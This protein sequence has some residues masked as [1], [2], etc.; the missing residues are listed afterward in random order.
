VLIKNAEALETMAKVNTLCIDKTGTL[1]EGRPQ[2]VGIE[3]SGMSEPD[4]IGVLASVEQGSEHPLAQAVLAAAKVRNIAPEPASGFQSH[5][6]KGV[7]ANVAAARIAF[8]N[9]LLMQEAGVELSNVKERAAELRGKGETVVFAAREDKYAGLVRMADPIKASAREALNE[10]R[11]QGIEVIM[12]TGDNQRTAQTIAQ[13]L[14]IARFEAEVLPQDKLEIV[15][16]LQTEGR[17]VAMA[18]DGINDAPALAQANVGIAMGSG[19]DIAMESADVTLVKGDLRG[20]L[21]AH[22]LSVATMRNIRQNL[23]FAFVYNALG[24]PIAAGVLYPVFGI[25]LSPMLA[26]AAMS[27]SSVSVIANSLRLRRVSI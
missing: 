27:F 18:G 22:N 14:G 8:G 10:L 7:T 16:K 17:R 20:I 12:L 23:F 3:A 21:R 6:G 4:L 19:T 9:E 15:K 25:L 5:G 2:V 26:A 1:T 11:Q 13:Q 24:V